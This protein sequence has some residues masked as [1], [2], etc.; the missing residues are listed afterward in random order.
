VDGPIGA[1]INQEANNKTNG[2]SF[3]RYHLVLEF[4]WE[5]VGF[6]W[7]RDIQHQQDKMRGERTRSVG[8]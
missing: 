5:R 7:S 3:L 6:W 1:A 2:L 8:Y 4:H